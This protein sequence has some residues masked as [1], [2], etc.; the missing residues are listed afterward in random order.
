MNM[1]TY[2]IGDWGTSRLR[3]HLCSG[4]RIIESSQGPGIGDC[5]DG[6]EAVFSGLIAEW[7][8]NAADCPVY[9]SGMVGSDM[10][11]RNTP[12]IPCPIDW[13]SIGDRCP[14]FMFNQHAVSIVP[15]LFSAN[16]LGKRDV[17][18]GEETQVLGAL[19]ENSQLRHGRQLLCLPG[20]HTKWIWMRDGIIERFL[21]AVTGELFAA[22]AGNTILLRTASQPSRGVR[23]GAAQGILESES[24]EQADL[25]HGLFQVRARQLFGQLEAG[26]SGAF[27]SG[28]I[29]GSDVRGVR[30]MSSEFNWN[31]VSAT[32][33]GTSPMSDEYAAA[34]GHY[35]IAGRVFD[36]DDMAT[37]GLIE[38]QERSKAKG[39]LNVAES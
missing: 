16:P 7:G 34:C 17:L 25:I 26:E 2:I 12:H 32:I 31:G 33:I 35:G 27:L 5:P 21:T 11:W 24:L 6:P 36:G 4:R 3:L 10:G 22:L 30:R 8:G 23:E 14:K 20:T 39:S 38:I 29:I 13:R 9:M 37:V 18:R 15:G 28:L 1:S 19:V